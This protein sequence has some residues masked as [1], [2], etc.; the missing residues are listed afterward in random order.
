MMMR[1]CQ[2]PIS[3]KLFGLN[4]LKHHTVDVN[5][6]D[7]GR[8]GRDNEQWKIELLGQWMLDG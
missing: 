1:Y 6:T 3:P 4:G 8:T 7:A 5:V 2:G